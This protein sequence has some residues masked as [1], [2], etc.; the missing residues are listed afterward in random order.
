MSSLACTSDCWTYNL[1]LA[2]RPA[3]VRG[4]QRGA[5]GLRV[6]GD[7]AVLRHARD[8]QRVDAVGVAIAVAAIL[9][10]AAVTRRPHE[11]GAQTAST[12]ECGKY[13]KSYLIV[14]YFVLFAEEKNDCLK[15]KF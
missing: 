9:V 4:G 7:L 13:V 3:A 11:D 2:G 1:P 15:T 14:K 6:P 8:G 10:A 5:A 12:L